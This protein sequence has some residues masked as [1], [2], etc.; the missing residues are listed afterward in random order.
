MVTMEEESK[1]IFCQYIILWGTIKSHFT[2]LQKIVSYNTE[3]P[4]NEVTIK[5]DIF[6]KKRTKF[7][8]IQSTIEI[9]CENTLN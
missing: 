8:S 5:L 1:E 2:N 3:L 9:A 4:R 6:K 7:D